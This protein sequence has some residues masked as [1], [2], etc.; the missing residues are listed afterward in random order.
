[1]Y[2]A[3]NV[4]QASG[5]IRKEGKLLKWAGCDESSESKKNSLPEDDPRINFEIKQRLLSQKK[6]MLLERLN[7]KKIEAITLN[8]QYASFKW[9]VDRNVSR[10][11]NSLNFDV[12]E[13]LHTPFV[14][15][16]S[17]TRSIECQISAENESV[18]LEYAGPLKLKDDL[19]VVQTLCKNSTVNFFQ[20]T[21]EISRSQNTASSIFRE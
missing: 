21:R 12:N 5:V 19:K 2:D 10:M 14:L 9:L 20:A 11:I 16:S 6:S 17:N 15:I 13:T 8:Q 4:L 1:V 7:S 18:L 3:L